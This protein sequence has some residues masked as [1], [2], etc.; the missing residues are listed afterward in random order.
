MFQAKL[1]TKKTFLSHTEYASEDWRDI[2]KNRV[3][4]IEP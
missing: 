3:V 2:N 4:L 1:V